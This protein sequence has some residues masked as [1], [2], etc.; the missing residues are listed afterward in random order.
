[1]CRMEPFRKADIESLSEVIPME[2]CKEQVTFVTPFSYHETA[3][4]STSSPSSRHHHPSSL[5]KCVKILSTGGSTAA[6]MSAIASKIYENPDKPAAVLPVVLASSSSSIK[7]RHEKAFDV[8]KHVTST[9]LRTVKQKKTIMEP[10]KFSPASFS[11]EKVLEEI[12]DAFKRQTSISTSVALFCDAEHATA[13]LELVSRGNMPAINGASHGGGSLSKINDT[14]GLRE[15][16][17][18]SSSGD[19]FGAGDIWY[20]PEGAI[21]TD[22]IRGNERAWRAARAVNLFS[23]GYL[24]MNQTSGG[25]AR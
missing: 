8:F 22:E 6:L 3:I 4:T 5:D 10:V 20:Y 15:E 16:M 12:K 1:M 14:E 21:W 24:G 9:Q 7:N 17:L 18:A 19:H 23:V 25:S 2:D 11:P 13:L